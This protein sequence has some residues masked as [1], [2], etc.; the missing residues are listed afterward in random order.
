M[1]ALKKNLTQGFPK[2]KIQLREY[3][4]NAI[5]L[6]RKLEDR[7]LKVHETANEIFSDPTV[8]NQM[9]FNVYFTVLTREENENE[10]KGYAAYRMWFL[11]NDDKILLSKTQRETNEHSSHRF[12][13]YAAELGCQEAILELRNYPR[14][15]LPQDDNDL[16][17]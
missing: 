15:Y 2:T 11:T 6:A 1:S 5:Q 3:T 13:I 7:A 16:K 8:L 9:A 17:K 14:D 4:L 12:L 10:L